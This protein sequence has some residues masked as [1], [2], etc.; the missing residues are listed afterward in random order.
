MRFSRALRTNRNKGVEEDIGHV[1]SIR[2][3]EQEPLLEGSVDAQFDAL[4]LVLTQA[5]KMTSHRIFEAP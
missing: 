3:E 1:L 2:F 4:F 5:D